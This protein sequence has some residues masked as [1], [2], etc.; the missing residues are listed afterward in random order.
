MQLSMQGDKIN[1][2]LPLWKK[3]I[4]LKPK[5]IVHHGKVNG[6]M[7]K[8]MVHESEYEYICASLLKVCK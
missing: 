1:I 6:L 8:V 2:L 7:P 3:E 5:I 4:G